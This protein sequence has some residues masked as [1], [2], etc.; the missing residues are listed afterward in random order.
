MRFV[1]F[2]LSVSSAWGNGHATL[3]RGLIH[4]L[5][6][7]GHEVVFFERDVP[8]YAQHRDLTELPGR[9]RLVLYGEL[10]DVETRARAALDDAD[11]AMVTSYC[12]AGP[13]A[14]EL[15]LQSRA[16]TRVFYDLDTPIT[17]ERLEAGE[18]VDYLPAGG[19]GGFDLVL[20]YTGGRALD[21]LRERL[22]ARRVAP[23]YGSVD[24]DRHAPAPPRAEWQ[25]DCSYLGTYAADRQDALDALFLGPARQRPEKKLVLGGSMY[26]EGFAWA[27]NVWYV[28]HVAPPDHPSFYASSPL[29]VSVTRGPMAAMGFC[30]SGRLFEAAA[31]GTPVLSDPWDGLD[32][33]YAPG[34]EILVARTTEDALAAIELP[35][36]ELARIAR[37]A[38]ERTLDEHT[39]PRRARELIALVE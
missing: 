29:T 3:W 2:G 28:A 37:R 35:R 16:R 25:G 5:D 20:S 38:R 8:Y 11:V 9:S 15:V 32:A 7:L 6:A 4:A 24:P 12:P 14:C 13:R 30:P 33:F 19:L 34:S 31:C 18:D 36:A 23:L 1:V 22:G 39:A 10:A 21:A 26:P 17:L 27:P